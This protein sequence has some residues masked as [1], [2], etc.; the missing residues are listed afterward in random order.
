[1][2]SGEYHWYNCSILEFTVKTGWKK[3]R[4][5]DMSLVAGASD[6]SLVARTISSHL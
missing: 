5:R 2:G 3:T 1:M 6:M 4:L